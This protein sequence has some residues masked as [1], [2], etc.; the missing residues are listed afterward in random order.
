MKKESKKE[1]INENTKKQ[2]EK[3]KK[4]SEKIEKKSKDLIIT[5]QPQSTNKETKFS[6]LINIIK[7]R[8][9][10]KGFTTIILIAIIIGIYIGVN[11][12]LDNVT[13]PEFDAT[14]NK[15]YTLSEET[16]NKLKNVDKEV[17]ITLINYND[18]DSIVEVAER[19]IMLNKNIK[20]EKIDNLASR[21]DL[22]EKYMLDTE[23]KLIIVSSE[24]NETL[25]SSYDLYTY[26]YST[27]E[28]IDRSEEAV[29]NAIV[30]VITKDKP[31]IYFMSNHALYNVDYYFYILMDLMKGD[32][33]EVCT[34]DILTQGSI[35]NDCDTLVIT[36]LSEDITTFEKDKILEYISRGGE[37]LLLNGPNVTGKKLTNFQEI[38]NQYGITIEEGIIYEGNSAN[39]MYQ[40]PDFIVEKMQNSSLTENLNM[41]L[42]ISFLGA[43]SIKFDEE[44]KEELNVDYEDLVY[45]SSKAFRRTNLE[46][47][48]KERTDL[49]SE[50][51]QFLI[52]GIVNKE[53]DKNNKSKL[54]VFGNE[55]FATNMTLEQIFTGSNNGTSYIVT[56]YQN[57]DVVL[58]SIAFLNERDDIITIRKDTTS[59]TYTATQMEHN[60]I[61]AIIF[62]TPLVIILV[63][64][65]VWQRRRRKR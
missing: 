4:Q 43:A 35:P 59:V 53:I 58:N 17:T 42:G 41:E 37:I 39:M 7:K 65:I 26:D 15:V 34:L 3:V 32:A 14:E 64:L 22:M 13:L 36:T 2:R 25:I 10:L 50:E 55:L 62:I 52:G 9:L 40:I 54:I 18:S 45:T 5:K 1:M 33:N 30:N 28:T 16:K 49:D 60:I 24:D 57:A 47:E 63:G 23:S 12:L 31:K 8:W 61:M 51:G 21:K 11:I 27:Y 29:T 38:L 48:A 20:V 56:L 19:Y 44:K 6:K 46:I